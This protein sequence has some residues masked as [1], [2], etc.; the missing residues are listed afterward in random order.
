[1]AIKAL[2]AKSF[3]KK[4]ELRSSSLP[5]DMKREVAMGDVLAI[6]ESDPTFSNGYWLVT[7]VGEWPLFAIEPGWTQNSLGMLAAMHDTWWLL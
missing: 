4:S 2:S 6:E 1:M 5:A 3:L 7:V